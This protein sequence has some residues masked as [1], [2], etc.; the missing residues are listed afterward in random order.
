MVRPSLKGRAEE[1]ENRTVA[2]QPDKL[3]TG[4]ALAVAGEH[5][6]PTMPVPKYPGD[7]SLAQAIAYAKQVAIWN[8]EEIMMKVKPKP[9]DPD[10]PARASEA[11][12]LAQFERLLGRLVIT[13]KRYEQSKVT[14]RTYDNARTGVIAKALLNREHK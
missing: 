2:L 4:R 12:V 13:E 6:R 7:L 8:I 11:Q 3:E 5:P 14:Q 10:M 9:D 1:G